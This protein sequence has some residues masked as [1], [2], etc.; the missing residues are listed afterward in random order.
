MASLEPNAETEK[1]QH[2]NLQ[3]SKSSSNQVHHPTSD[4]RVVSNEIA[5]VRLPKID[6]RDPVRYDASVV[7]VTASSPDGL[8][9]S[10]QP[11]PPPPPPP[12]PSPS[13]P[14]PPQQRQS[15]SPPFI[16]SSHTSTSH[17]SQSIHPY[18]EHNHTPSN[19]NNDV[20]PQQS[21][22]QR[23]RERRRQTRQLRA[24]E[25]PQES[26]FNQGT[27]ASAAS[28][29]DGSPY[30]HPSRPSDSSNGSGSTSSRRE[31]LAAQYNSSVQ[32][33]ASA[34]SPQSPSPERAINHSSSSP[35][36]GWVI[37]HYSPSATAGLA[38]N[39][40]SPSPRT[41]R[42]MQPSEQGVRSPA[43]RTMNGAFQLNSG[44]RP[45]A[46]SIRLPIRPLGSS[47]DVSD[48]WRSWDEVRVKVFSLPLDSTTRDLW[49][50]FQGEGSILLIDIYEDRTGS[51][52]G[53]ACLTFR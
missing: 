27:N 47:P 39:H 26:V 16:P 25:R 48:D 38:I 1:P 34:Y 32:Q 3:L 42:R 33:L 6:G 5:A 15:P 35:A 31:L 10:H 4:K 53:N 37:N 12:P 41:G 36:T 20:T 19:H 18:S 45:V 14:P 30:K 50:W 11:P 17:T 52:D 51:R 46:N 49:V 43:G 13:P 7:M 40:S 28:Y 8:A 21:Q 22:F 44:P 29:R 23:R 9:S 2:P 24:M